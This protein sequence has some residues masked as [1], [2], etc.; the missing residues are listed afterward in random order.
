MKA[1]GCMCFLAICGGLTVVC[2]P[3][4]VGLLAIVLVAKALM[5]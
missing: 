2:W 4:G 1:L 5:R 3:A